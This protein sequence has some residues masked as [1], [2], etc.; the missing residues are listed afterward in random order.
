MAKKVREKRLAQ[1]LRECNKPEI[2]AMGIFLCFAPGSESLDHLHA[3]VFG[4]KDTP[5]EGGFFLFSIKPGNDYPHTPPVFKFITPMSLGCRM[6]PN[7]YES[8]SFAP[9]KVC[10]SILNT[11]G[12][13]EY[14]AA[15]TLQKILMTI[16][17][18]LDNAPANNEPGLEGDKVQ[19][20]AYAIAARCWT[21]ITAFQ[22][23]KRKDMSDEFRYEVKKFFVNNLDLYLKSIDVVKSKMPNYASYEAPYTFR[24]YH[25]GVSIILGPMIR[26]LKNMKLKKLQ[27]D[28]EKEEEKKS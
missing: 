5:Y 24:Y 20:E 13:N 26:Q 10:L 23:L 18:L 21:L 4:P 2:K 11:W 28:K 12:N 17:S 9:G 7:L 8:E 15:L 27:L 25:G 1:E 14:S 3:L 16:L 6:H 22:F 19:N